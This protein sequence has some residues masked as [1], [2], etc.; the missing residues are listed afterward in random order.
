MQLFILDFSD[1][2]VTCFRN[3]AYNE[4]ANTKPAGGNKLSD[5]VTFHIRGLK[6]V[7]FWGFFF[8][9]SQLQAGRA[10]LP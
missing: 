5:S 1:S 8:C 4:Q 9:K 2:Q 7:S 6:T 10:K 3:T